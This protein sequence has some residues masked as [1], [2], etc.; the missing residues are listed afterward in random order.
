MTYGLGSDLIKKSNLVLNKAPLL[1]NLVKYPVG[2]IFFKE[3]N[4]YPVSHTRFDFSFRLMIGKAKLF[5]KTLFLVFFS[6][7]MSWSEILSGHFTSIDK[8][9]VN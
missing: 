2:S 3:L 1:L 9:Q 5:S 4:I 8:D 6:A 7:G